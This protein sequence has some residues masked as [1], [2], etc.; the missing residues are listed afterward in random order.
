[1]TRPDH[2]DRFFVCV[3]K[4]AF[5]NDYELPDYDCDSDDE[6]WLKSKPSLDDVDVMRFEE[7]MDRLEK[8]T[9]FSTNLMT[10]DEAK[11]ILK[12]EDNDVIKCIYDYWREKRI[13]LVSTTLPFFL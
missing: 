12:H 9:G 7:I 13:K 6:E 2:I 5:L 4:I 1:M 11:F 8:A 10:F 3:K